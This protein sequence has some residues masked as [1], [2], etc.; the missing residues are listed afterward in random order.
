[1][2]TDQASLDG[3]LMGQCDPDDKSSTPVSRGNAQIRKV[4]NVTALTSEPHMA[5]KINTWRET[6]WIAASTGQYKW[7]IPLLIFLGLMAAVAETLG[8]GLAVLFLFS[9]LG[10]SNEVIQNGGLLAGMLVRV[11]TTL[12][13]NPTFLASIFFLLI[14]V[15]ALLVYLNEIVTALLLND[16]AHRVRDR[17]H[18]HYVTIGYIYLQ[19]REH[20]ALLN[21][22]ST[23]SWGVADAVYD[24]SRIG[25]HICAVTVFAIGMF[26]L[27]WIIALTAI[28]CAFLVFVLLRLLSRVAQRLGQ[29]TLAAN[30]ILAE[31]MLVSLSGM[32]TLRA[33]AKERHMLDVFE[34]VSGRVKS[35]NVRTARV[36]ALLGP[37][38]E[39]AGL[40]TLIFV[41]LLANQT[42]VGVPT[43]I[44]SVL[45][46]FRLQPHLYAIEASRVSLAG[47][48]ASL[49]NVRQMLETDDKPWP[50][51]GD[52]PFTGLQRQIRFDNVAFTHDPRR[53]PS[54]SRISFTIPA[55]QTTM[56]SGPSGSGKT[57]ILN[58]LLR[59]Y[60]PEEGMITVDGQNLS[61]FTRKH[62]L[63]R[64]AIAGQDIEL[65]DSTIAENIRLGRQNATEEELCE[66]CRI[67][68]ILDNIQ[69]L[70][71]GFE[72]K[73]GAAGLN[74]SGGQRQRIGLARALLCRPDLLILDEAMSALEPEREDRIRRRI[75][76]QM[77][78]LTILIVSHRSNP[79]I[80]AD[81]IVQIEN[82]EIFNAS[83]M[84]AH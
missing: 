8:V 66:V 60:E 52:R 6:A 84:A 41:A 61:D 65:I 27:S 25:V 68:E 83:E 43:V 59:L 58:L 57:T 72:T 70:P 23:E 12:G 48:G 74:F 13:A 69:A 40:G 82:G 24:L 49:H 79:K 80:E 10:Q 26:S 36:K 2:E 46:L 78:G 21:T 56:L 20:G 30:Q 32:R 71:D 76:E 63:S 19:K 44:A 29:E 9:L 53:G 38:G 14:L 62:W 67:V 50:I 47:M 3:L 7:A 81:Q 75:S 37:I 4:K 15:K 35:L 16:I 77:K 17:L 34:E 39:A 11:E 22:L 18:R 5:N 31:R 45:L 73:I 55:G 42:G 64:V 28:F 54:V 33:F 1:M 51:E